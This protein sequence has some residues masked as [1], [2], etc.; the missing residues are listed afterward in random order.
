[1]FQ[2][3]LPP[4][5]PVPLQLVLSQPQQTVIPPGNPFLL[6]PG[7]P[8]RLQPPNKLPSLSRRQRKNRSSTIYRKLFENDIKDGGRY[9]L[10]KY[11]LHDG[12]CCRRGRFHYLNDLP[13]NSLL[14]M[15]KE[16]LLQSR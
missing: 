12:C 7:P 10:H 9:I 16:N 5:Q 15:E 6:Q 4:P 13:G 14:Y 3:Q 8:L 2:L 11:D 1:M